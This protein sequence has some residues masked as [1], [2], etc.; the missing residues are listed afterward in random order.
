MHGL[1]AYGLGGSLRAPAPG[2]LS[3]TIET[4]E[5]RGMEARAMALV[6]VALEWSEVEPL[7]LAKSVPYQPIRK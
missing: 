5:R 6:T 2:L 1:P 4:V 3:S 7:E